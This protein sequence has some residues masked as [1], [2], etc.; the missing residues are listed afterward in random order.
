MFGWPRTW[1][2]MRSRHGPFAVRDRTVQAKVLM[3]LAR[4]ISEAR[5]VCHV[6]SFRRSAIQPDGHNQGTRVAKVSQVTPLVTQEQSVPVS[7]SLKGAKMKRSLFSLALVL[8]LTASPTNVPS[9][10]AQDRSPPDTSTP[11]TTDS[12][13]S[14]VRSDGTFDRN[15]GWIGLVGLVGLFGLA[16]KTATHH[17]VDKKV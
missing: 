7:F 1:C 17:Q 11:A 5:I 14:G 8:I 6:Q 16:G 15:M 12:S 3:P 9:S 13:R 4:F 2:A 10:F